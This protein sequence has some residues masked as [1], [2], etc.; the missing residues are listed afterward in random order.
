MLNYKNM[1]KINSK[2]ALKNMRRKFSIREFMPV[3][4]SVICGFVAMAALAL[5][6]APAHAQTADPI[7]GSVTY[8]NTAKCPVG[9]VGNSSCYSLSIQCSGIDGSG[10]GAIPVTVKVTNPGATKGAIIFVS[11]GGGTSYYDQSFTY[12]EVI[13]NSVL[14][15]GFTAIQPYFGTINGW[16]QGPA[17]NGARS[18]SCRFAALANWAATSTSPLMHQSGTAMCAAGV[19]AGSSVVVYSLAHYGM[20]SGATRLFDMVE[21]TS[22]P[23]FGRLDHGCICNQPPLQ[24][25]TGQGPLSD[26][27]LTIGTLV[28]NT[29]ST[30]A[31]SAAKKTH[32]TTNEELLYH[33]SIMSDDQPFLNYTTA[34]HV[35]FG[36]QNDE[37]A[38]IPQG[39]E[40]ANYVTSPITVNVVQDAAH[41]VPDSFDGALQVANDLNTSCALQTPKR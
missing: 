12:G 31:C 37:G 21:I 40:W 3:V 11:P 5:A 38:A 29:Y 8:L 34:V 25:S 41:L 33:D 35:V 23:T 19:S 16:L 1:A 32:S 17:P 4:G 36:A 30:A 2:F 7:N 9:G 6:S 24:T 20:G 14:Q 10:V 15:A 28:D 27:Y 22:G 26:C 13:V 39:L 18:L